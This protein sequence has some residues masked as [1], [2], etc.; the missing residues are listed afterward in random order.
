MVGGSQL[1]INAAPGNAADPG[2]R[3]HQ[4]LSESIGRQ[5]GARVWSGMCS[6]DVRA[7]PAAAASRG[8]WFVANNELLKVR[9]GRLSNAWCRAER[10]ARSV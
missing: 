4:S 8:A 5:D 2:R 9:D 7:A 6:H 3:D 1:R 10:A